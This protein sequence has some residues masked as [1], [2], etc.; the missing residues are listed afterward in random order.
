MIIEGIIAKAAFDVAALPVVEMLGSAI[1]GGAVVG[2]ANAV[3]NYN[4]GG[5][6]SKE[7]EKKAPVLSSEE[8]YMK[9]FQ[10][11]YKA[12]MKEMV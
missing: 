1:V 12:C 8:A 10:E 4:N 2:T 3:H 5:S 7:E 6:S 11:G 9:A